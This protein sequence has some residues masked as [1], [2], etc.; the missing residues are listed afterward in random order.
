MRIAK[1]QNIF[2]V[3]NSVYLCDIVPVDVVIAVITENSKYK[4][5]QSR[6][7]YRHIDIVPDY[8]YGNHLYKSKRFYRRNQRVYFKNTA[9]THSR[10]VALNFYA[11]I[12]NNLE[13]IRT[14]WSKSS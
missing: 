9:E 10:V 7:A 3:I 4:S 8:A 1:N 5:L 6:R 14:F 13:F 11:V 2:S 12:Q